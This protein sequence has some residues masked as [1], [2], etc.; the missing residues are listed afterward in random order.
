MI[1][2]AP[3]GAFFDERRSKHFKLVKDYG[4]IKL[5]GDKDDLATITASHY[6]R[7]LRF[8]E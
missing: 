3:S 8:D 7:R 1:I 5:G 6:D 2:K 4:K